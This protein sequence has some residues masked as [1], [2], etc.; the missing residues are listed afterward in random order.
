MTRLHYLLV[1]KLIA[2]FF[3]CYRLIIPSDTRLREGIFEHTPAGLGEGKALGTQTLI[4]GGLGVCRV[5]SLMWK[6]WCILKYPNE[7]GELMKHIGSLQSRS[8]SRKSKRFE[9]Q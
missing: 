8:G 7:I 3:S 1:G 5:A 6:D 9:G 4:L 2:C